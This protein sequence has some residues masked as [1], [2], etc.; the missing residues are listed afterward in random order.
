MFRKLFGLIVYV[1]PMVLIYFGIPDPHGGPWPVAPWTATGALV[2][3]AVLWLFLSNRILAIGEMR[4]KWT[5]TIRRLEQHSTTV[6][7]DV[8][9]SDQTDWGK[10]GHRVEAT[11]GFPNLAGT[12]VRSK[13][14][15]FDAQPEQ[16]RFEAGKQVPVRLSLDGFNPPATIVGASAELRGPRAVGLWALFNVVAATGIFLFAYALQSAG[17]GWLFMHF[18]HPWLLA[19]IPGLVLLFFL[20]IDLD[21]DETWKPD[22][23]LNGLMASETEE[24]EQYGELLLHGRLTRGALVNYK[25][26]PGTGQEGAS[27]LELTFAFANEADEVERHSFKQNFLDAEVGLLERGVETDILYLPYKPEIFAAETPP[28]EIEWIPNRQKEIAE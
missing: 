23:E 4:R 3:G 1:L 21:E 24:K 7:A 19:P 22:H 25:R 18:F 28:R 14:T 15:F 10:D 2:V 11:I 8:I 6:L 27:T 20:G 9:E 12:Y 16:R 17:D 13:V 26:V 5:R